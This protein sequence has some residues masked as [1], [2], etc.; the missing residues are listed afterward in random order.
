M[1]EA[2][3]NDVCGL[4]NQVEMFYAGSGRVGECL[5]KISADS[6]NKRKS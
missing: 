4:T 1:A 3:N 5:V 6:V 2:Q